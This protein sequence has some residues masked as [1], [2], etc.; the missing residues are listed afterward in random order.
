LKTSILLPIFF[1][2]ITGCAPIHPAAAYPTLPAPTSKVV[3]ASHPGQASVCTHV[4]GGKLNVRANANSRAAVLGVLEEGAVVEMLENGE[5]GSGWVE[6]R[7][8]L[9]GWVNSHFLC[10]GVQ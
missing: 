8:P 3:T 4:A 2:A 10:G 7:S 6:I 5:T 1:M 9:L